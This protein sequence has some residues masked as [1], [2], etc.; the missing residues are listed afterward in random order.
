MGGWDE[1]G[2]GWD[3][4]GVGWDGI[5]VGWDQKGMGQGWDRGETGWDR[6]GGGVGWYRGLTGSGSLRA[7]Q[8]LWSLDILTLLRG[9]HTNIVVI[10]VMRTNY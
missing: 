5:R 10:V 9:E 1:I 8:G 2:S 3:G 4:N 6:G 7:R